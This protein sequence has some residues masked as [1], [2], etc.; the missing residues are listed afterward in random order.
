METVSDVMNNLQ[1]LNTSLHGKDKIVSDF[2]Q[3]ILN[4]QKKI[5]L[6]Q[7]DINTK[8]LLRF[9]LL[10]SLVN[11]KND[12]C[13]EKTKVYVESLEGAS[14][15]LVTRFSGLENLRPS[16]AFLVNPF[17]VDIVKDGCP[18]QKPI[19]TQTANK[20]VEVLD[21]QQHVDIKSVHQSQTTVEF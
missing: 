3:T 16:L 15:N 13:S 14:T 4:C 17:V 6:F 19:A 21:L 2:A 18:V 20:K 1:A 9:P 8:S 11:S 7:R 5:T 12:S 10:K